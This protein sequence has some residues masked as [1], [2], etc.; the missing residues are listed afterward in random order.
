MTEFWCCL[1]VHSST[2]T[3]H[4]TLA[5]IPQLTIT[6]LLLTLKFWYNDTVFKRLM[7]GVNS[8]FDKQRNCLY[9]QVYRIGVCK[10]MQFESVLLVISWTSNL[11]YIRSNY[12]FSLLWKN[13][14]VNMTLTS[15]W[16]FFFLLRI[17]LEMKYTISLVQKYNSSISPS[18]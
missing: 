1:V 5:S 4:S 13:S 15:M 10:W 7:D 11:F 3:L 17:M 8:T 16:C 12:Y 14:Y 9:V 18:S 2:S 6:K